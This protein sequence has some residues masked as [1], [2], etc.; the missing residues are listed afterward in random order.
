VA[1]IWSE[2]LQ[3]KPREGTTA[4]LP[5]VT[6]E[7]AESANFGVHVVCP[8]TV[9]FLSELGDKY[10][11]FY[12]Q[13][14]DSWGDALA[15][16]LLMSED[17]V[18]CE[19]RATF[20]NVRGDGSQSF[21]PCRARVLPTG[22]VI[23]PADS[24]PVRLPFAR[25]LSVQVQN[26]RVNVETSDRGVFELLRMGTSYQNFSDKFIAARRDFEGDSFQAIVE[27]GPGLGFDRLFMLSKMMAEGRAISRGEVVKMVYDFWLTLERSVNESPLAAS[28]SHL[29][30]LAVEDLISIGFWKT[31]RADHV[32]FMMVIPGSVEKG[33]NSV[34]LEVTSVTGHATYLFRVLERGK[35][36]TSA[37]GQFQAA[38]RELLRAINEALVA[39]GFRR[40]PIYIDE[41]RLSAPAYNRYLYASKN[42][43]ELKLLRERFYARIIHGTT[44]V[45]ASD[46]NEA[47]LFNVLSADDSAKWEKS[48]TDPMRSPD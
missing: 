23:L 33:G 37:P 43:P 40:E 42:V 20:I 26:F 36:P 19:A 11:S 46:L 44:E 48:Q 18:M 8:T 5:Y 47:L 39:T 12:Q 2:G 15:R 38:A 31:F 25:I 9:I 21:G 22:L 35:F 45:W 30:S 3:L 7:R 29:K 1:E 10:D 14:T 32:W 13:L 17:K 6:I 4:F 34:A 24:L 41:A 28:Y 27:L 16:A